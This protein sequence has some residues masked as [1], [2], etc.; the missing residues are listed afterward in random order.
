LLFTAYASPVS[1]VIENHGVSYHQLADDAQLYI[2]M[3]AA[4]TASTLDRPARCTAAVK[5]WFLLNDLPLNSD[6]SEVLVFSTTAHTIVSVKTILVAKN[7][8]GKMNM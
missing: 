4:E 1:D 8:L 7:L 2:A 5:R 6:K 3:N